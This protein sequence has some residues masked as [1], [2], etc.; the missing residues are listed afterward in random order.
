LAQTNL[1]TMLAYASLSHVGLVLLGIAAFSLQ[2]IQ[3]AV[4]QLL[5]FTLVAGGAFLATAFV[6]R[7][8][9][10][11][12]IANMG[13]AARSMPLLAGCF[14]LFGLAGMGVPGTSGFPAELL[15]LVATL[16]THAGAGLAALFVMVLSAAYFLDLYRRAFFGPA[17]SPAVAEALDLR[18]RELVLILVFVALILGF[19]LFPAPLLDLIEPSAA[20][21]AANLA[22]VGL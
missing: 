18:P 17:A 7:R 10:S 16:E 5:N 21:W 12:D 15:I 11:T 3:G 13:G 1:R 9:G 14:L 6:R 19:G 20:A 8:L 22:R 4:L 2:G